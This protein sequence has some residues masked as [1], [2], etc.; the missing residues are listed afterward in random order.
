PSEGI[1][2]LPEESLDKFAGKSGLGG[3][4]LEVRDTRAG[5]TDPPP[6]LISWQLSLR[7]RN[8]A[9]APLPLPAGD[10][11]TNILGAGQIQWF[12]VDAPPWVSFATNSL[13]GASAPVNLL[14][15]Q[16]S[17]PTGT[18]AGDFTLLGGALSGSSL[19]ATNGLPSFAPGSRWYLGIQNTNA[20]AVVFALQVDFDVSNVV[21]LA[22]GE[23]VAGTNSGPAG[24]VDYYRFVVST[25]GVRAQFE[26]NGPTSDLALVARKG[27]PLPGPS[28]FDYRS[29]N[30][31]TNDEL[32]VVYDF[33]QP[34]PLTS[35]EWF[36]GVVNVSG[37]PAGY[38]IM[39]TEFPQYGT[40]IVI[41][42]ETVTVSNVCLTWSSLPGAHYYIEGTAGFDDTNWLALSPTLTAND[43][44]SS[45]CL[46]L[47]SPFAFFRVREGLVII[48]P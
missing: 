36:L 40:N 28:R 33:S 7:F 32:I 8:S 29:D 4:T 34:V 19:L 18:N 2:Y 10:A 27:L 38:S 3:W 30:P 6:T 44:I 26:I 16:S 15:N 25:N 5:G 12:A 13:L 17:P 41:Q 9:P 48:P 20:D 21:T 31:Y 42:D 24:A 22:S 14:F 37:A 46:D 45:Y 39:A 43:I 1:Y 47:P 35:G 11:T 23:A